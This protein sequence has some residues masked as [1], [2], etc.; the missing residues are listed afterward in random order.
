MLLTAHSFIG[1]VKA[2]LPQSRTQ[3]VPY[4]ILEVEFFRTLAFGINLHLS[5]MSLHLLAEILRGPIRW[6]LAG[7]TILRV[8]Y[9]KQGELQTLLETMQIA[10][11]SKGAS[12]SGVFLLD[13]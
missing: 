12:K 13:P 3:H 4:A 2:R 6:R 7:D 11:D 1:F 8:V 5:I 10:H 9:L